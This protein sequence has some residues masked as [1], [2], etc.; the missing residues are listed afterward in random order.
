MR[1]ERQGFFLRRNGRE[2]F[3]VV[4]VVVV[5]TDQ[6]NIGTTGVRTN[7]HAVVITQP[8]LAIARGALT[9]GGDTSGS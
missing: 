3:V 5:K 8:I 2:Y 6:T 7:G 9:L 4:V 1:L